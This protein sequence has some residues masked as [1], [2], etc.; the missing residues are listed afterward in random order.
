MRKDACQARKTRFAERLE[1]AAQLVRGRRAGQA[2]MGFIDLGEQQDVG[3][4]EAARKRLGRRLVALDQG[5]PRIGGDLPD[6]T[7]DLDGA[8]ASQALQVAQ[9]EALVATSQTAVG[10]PAFDFSDD[11][12]TGAVTF[13]GGA[14]GDDKL[15]IEVPER[16]LRTCSIFS[17][18]D[19]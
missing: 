8:V 3:R 11:V 7:P 15:D 12:I 17:I 1:G 13:T 16:K 4:L 19:S 5:P 2:T 18:L 14:I 6:Q 9:E 10:K